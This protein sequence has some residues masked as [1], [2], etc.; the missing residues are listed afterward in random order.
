MA[1]VSKLNSND[2]LFVFSVGGGDIE[3]NISPNIVLALKYA[4]KVGSKITGV[5]GKEGGYTAKVADACVIIPIVNKS[6][7]TPHTEAFQAVVWHLLDP[8]Q[9]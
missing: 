2:G 4:K 5:V 3:K 7:I 8:I 9:N 1:K 6:T